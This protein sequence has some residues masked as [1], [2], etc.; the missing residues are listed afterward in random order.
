MALP[1]CRICNRWHESI[2]CEYEMVSVRRQDLKDVLLSLGC[3]SDYL[4]KE[5][6]ERFYQIFPEVYMS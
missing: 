1:K 2:K 6:C 4:P 3:I 5:A